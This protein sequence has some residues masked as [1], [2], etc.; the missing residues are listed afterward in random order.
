MVSLL[1][2]VAESFPDKRTGA[3]RHFS[4]CDI[5]LA[6]F[7]VFFTQSESFLD[8]QRQIGRKNGRHNL[9]SLFGVADVPSDNHIRSMLDEVEALRVYPVFGRILDELQSCGELDRWRS[10][11]NDIVLTVDGTEYFR[12]QK[13]HCS[14]CHVSNHTSGMVDYSHKLLSPAIV[15]P[16]ES[17]AIAL[18]PEFIRG[19]DGERKAEGELSAA[20]RWVRTNGERLSPLGVT[21][22][23]DDIYA[24]GPFLR[25]LREYEMNF[26]CVCKP[27]SHKY[28]T[29]YIASLEAE[30]E[31][32]RCTESVRYRGRKRTVSYRW[33]ADVPL[34]AEAD[35]PIVDWVEVRIKEDSGRQVYANSFVTNHRVTAD[36][37]AEVVAAGRARWKVENED[38]NTLKTKGYHLEHNF[39][40]GKKNLCETLATLNILAFLMH[41]ILDLYD[42]RYALLRQ[43]RGRRTRFFQEL[44]TLTGY[45]YFPNWQ[46]VLIFM[47]EQ[48]EL[49]DPGG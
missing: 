42:Q 49:P 19:E 15:K 45:I 38:I 20:K 6:A 27:Q 39:G 46:A 2:E 7:S 17:R 10:V 14:R 23:G 1:R 33:I 3:N 30:G 35:A 41:T 4:M 22:C 47:I 11:G 28:L 8:F 44:G 31:I 21:V 13:I 9:A 34:S 12:S 26:V 43:E 37:V 18:A 29:E 32:E 24:S 16:G 25:L 48:L 5:T 36:T 40:H